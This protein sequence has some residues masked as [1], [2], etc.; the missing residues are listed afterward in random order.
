MTNLL[1]VNSSPN[2]D[3]SVTRGLS[4]EFADTLASQLGD[5]TVVNRD[6]GA[7]PPPHLDQTT[8]GAF[9]TPAENRS[10]EQKLAVALSDTLI[11][12]L[13]N[14]DVIVI[15]APMHN[16]GISSSLKTWFDHV[17]R[18]GETF[19]YT[20]NGPQGLLGGKKVYVITARG[21]DYS[22]TSPA[23]AMDIQAP[24]IKT[25]LGFVGITDVTFI[26]GHGLAM[27]DEV[28]EKSLEAARNAISEATGALAA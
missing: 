12:E 8:I 5:L 2:L 25:V 14:A 11:S 20:E 9:Y 26:H 13:K 24:Y 3:A 21:G 15:G 18:V 23:A 7:T 16:F 6:L 19:Q 4:K 27:G 28:R 1:V 10:A 22:E 17:A